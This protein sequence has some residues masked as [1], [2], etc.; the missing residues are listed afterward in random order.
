MERKRRPWYAEFSK[1]IR[2]EVREEAGDRCVICG[3]SPCTF[4]HI[5][6]HSQGGPPEKHNAACLCPECHRIA[7]RYALNEKIYYP[8]VVIYVRRERGLEE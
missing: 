8:E 5:V 3:E 7:D 1:K 4:H 6:P 2:R